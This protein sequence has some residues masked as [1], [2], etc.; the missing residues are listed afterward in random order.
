MIVA[1]YPVL[2]NVF[3]G[4]LV[5]GRS[6][7][8]ANINLLLSHC[9]VLPMVKTLLEPQLLAFFMKRSPKLDIIVSKAFLN[10]LTR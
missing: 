2:F 6:I 8:C 10:W 5:Y 9:T 1:G 7:G 4:S 3:I